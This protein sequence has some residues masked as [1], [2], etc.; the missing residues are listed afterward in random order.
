MAVLVSGGK[1]TYIHGIVMGHVCTHMY[2]LYNVHVLMER[3]YQSI[4][5]G[6]LTV[7]TE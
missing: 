3:S 4:P 2:V 7:H 5:S 1:G 6:I